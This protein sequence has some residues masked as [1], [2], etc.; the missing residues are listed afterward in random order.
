MKTVK[1]TLGTF[2]ASAA[3]VL[4]SSTSFAQVYK[5]VDSQGHTHYSS[6]KDDARGARTDELKLPAQPAPAPSA[7]PSAERT[8]DQ[9]RQTY[10][11]QAYE[12]APISPPVSKH[13]SSLSGGR[14]DG[15]DAS[16]CALAKDVLSGA[17]QHRN[18]KPTDKYD[19]DVAQSDVQLFC[20]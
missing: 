19:R 17:V 4:C 20:H 7:K 16:R 1:T 6:N 14:E 18:G 15:S 8:M 11:R 9:S 13:P 12:R 10:P 3:L 5:W 2:I